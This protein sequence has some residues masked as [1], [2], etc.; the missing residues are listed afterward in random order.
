MRLRFVK[1][2]GCVMWKFFSSVDWLGL[3]NLKKT[4]LLLAPSGL[5]LDAAFPFLSFVPD[6]VPE[7]GHTSEHA[8]RIFHA[9]YTQLIGKIPITP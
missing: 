9:G 2:F 7:L 6:F 8:G 3:M 4:F 5:V 1:Y